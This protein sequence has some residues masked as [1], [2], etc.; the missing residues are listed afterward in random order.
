[1]SYWSLWA[2]GVL[3]SF[4]VLEAYGLAHPDRMGSLSRAM[5]KL[6]ASLPITIAIWGA[7]VGGL[8]VH[9]FWHFCP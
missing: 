7:I 9:F 1:M 2:L 5:A 4:G 3:G 6:G 8:S